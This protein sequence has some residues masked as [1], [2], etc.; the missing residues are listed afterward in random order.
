M[1]VAAT[2]LLANLAT[3]PSTDSA[4]GRPV[5]PIPAVA[6]TPRIDR[7]GA[8]ERV[9]FA[10]V[11]G[12]VTRQHELEP[13]SKGSP[14]VPRITSGQA[15]GIGALNGAIAGGVFAFK[16]CQ[17]DDCTTPAPV[18]IF[19]VGGAVLGALVGLLLGADPSP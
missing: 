11:A 6:A 14:M 9:V 12:V 4:E 15:S 2:L 5:R 8:S 13:L 7:G 19:A 10:R 1:L 3:V 16:L 18:A 17:R